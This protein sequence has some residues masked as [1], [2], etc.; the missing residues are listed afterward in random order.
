KEE[1]VRT[2]SGMVHTNR[3]QLKPG[4]ANPPIFTGFAVQ[5]PVILLGNPDDH[6]IIK[7][8]RD[9]KFL[10]YLPAAATMPGPGRGYFAWQRDGVGAGQESFVL[11]AY[12]QAGMSEAVGSFY[13]AATGIERLTK[14]RLADEVTISPA[15]SATVPPAAKVAWTLKL[16][17]R[18]DG[19]GPGNR[20]IVALSHDGTEAIIF[21]GGKIA[22]T[23][24]LTGPEL[25]G[26]RRNLAP[27]PLTADAQKFARPDRSIKL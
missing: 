23:K 2:W 9:E 18:I 13:E 8:L 12:D 19:I 5:G 15:K 26:E 4:D 25:D 16:P 17:D 10:P 6:D 24:V 14:H 1:E 7:F 20:T 11:L 21:T 3:G 22:T 27:K